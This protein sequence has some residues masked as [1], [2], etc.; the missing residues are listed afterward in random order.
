M[1]IDWD[2]HLLNMADKAM[3]GQDIECPSCGEMSEYDADE[4]EECGYSSPDEDTR[5]QEDM[6][7]LNRSN[8]P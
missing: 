6:Y 1:S 2:A 3:G 8:E 5:T 4:C 7:Y